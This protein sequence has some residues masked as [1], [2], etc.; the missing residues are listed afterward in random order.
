MGILGRK[1]GRLPYLP[2]KKMY[3]PSL[4]MHIYKTSVLSFSD[5]GMPL[6]AFLIPL[7]LKSLTLLLKPCDIIFKDM[8]LLI[9]F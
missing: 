2:F 7:K 9:Y 1:W 6:T 3:C 5:G 4:Y 8:E